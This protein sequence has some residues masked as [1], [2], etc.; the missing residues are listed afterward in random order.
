[1]AVKQAAL[2][3]TMR[4]LAVPCCQKMCLAFSGGKGALQ[5]AFVSVGLGNIS[6]FVTQD[7]SMSLAMCTGKQQWKGNRNWLDACVSECCHA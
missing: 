2:L 6:H 3:S 7:I 5:N 1:M 4:N